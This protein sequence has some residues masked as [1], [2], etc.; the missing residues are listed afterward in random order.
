MNPPPLSLASKCPVVAGREVAYL[1]LTW[2]GMLFEKSLCLGS[3]AKVTAPYNCTQ[4][5]PS[6]IKATR[7][8]G[9][10]DLFCLPPRLSGRA[11]SGAWVICHMCLPPGEDL[12]LVV[13]QVGGY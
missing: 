13:L 2:L 4:S 12:Y 7:K 3:A 6:P 8:R 5:S 1:L 9:R 11:G 10:M